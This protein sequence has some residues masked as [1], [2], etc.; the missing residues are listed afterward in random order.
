MAKAQEGV[1]NA[2]LN[3]RLELFL[4]NHYEFASVNEIVQASEIAKELTITI[5]KQKTKFIW[6]F[7]KT[8]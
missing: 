7:S 2:S 8:I 1:K 5:T 3:K 4:S 6:I